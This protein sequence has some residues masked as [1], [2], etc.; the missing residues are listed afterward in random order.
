MSVPI[1]PPDPATISEDILNLHNIIATRYVGGASLIRLKS[2]QEGFQAQKTLLKN[3]RKGMEGE[4]MEK[5][6]R[7][8][9]D[10]QAVYLAGQCSYNNFGGH[11]SG[12][13]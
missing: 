11:G 10:Q 7:L 13:Y 2:A 9:S 4:G 12:K 3:I 1:S 8:S 6:Y 5:V